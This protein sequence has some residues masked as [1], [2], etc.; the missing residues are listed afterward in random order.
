ME[1][2]I[3]EGNGGKRQ[4]QGSGYGSAA[5]DILGKRREAGGPRIRLGGNGDGII[6]IGAVENCAHWEKHAAHKCQCAL[7]KISLDEW[8]DRLSNSD[9][10][11]KSVRHIVELETEILMALEMNLNEATEALLDEYERKKHLKFDDISKGVQNHYD[12]VMNDIAK[13]LQLYYRGLVNSSRDDAYMDLGIVREARMKMLRKKAA[14]GNNDSVYEKAVDRAFTKVKTVSHDVIEDLKERWLAN[15]GPTDVVKNFLLDEEENLRGEALH[16]EDLR[17]RLKQ[18]WMKRRYIIQRIIRTETVNTHGTVQLN[19]WYEQGIREVERYEINDLKT[20]SLCRALALPGRNVYMIEDLLRQDYPV[21]YIS[22]PQCRGGY[23][24]RQNWSVFDDF[25]QKLNDFTNVQDIQGENGS[26]A[27]DVP[28]E[29]QTQVEKALNDFG[30]DYDIKFVPDI[31]DSKEWQTD[32]QKYWE[33]FY[34]AHDATVRVDLEKD[35]NRGKYIQ[36]ITDDGQVLV[37]G[38]AGDINRVVIPV[39]REKARQAYYG[40]EEADRQWVDE[41]YDRKKKEMGYT[42]EEEGVQI[43]GKVPFISPLAEHSAAD[44]FVESYTSYVADPTRLFYLDK[45]MYDFLRSK[46]MSTEYLVRGGIK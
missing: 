34:D 21:T 23:R 42:L 46:C 41:E 10:D 26:V 43:I 18:L 32:R 20:C 11:A 14:I 1:L 40:L 28:I 36:Y 39:L 12:L 25:E 37:S 9:M 13:P 5:R 24:P 38:D 8:R 29:Y 27:K 45:R 19:E 35:D 4:G 17:E 33:N 15:G 3:S 7:K 22:H 44:Y 31:V 16:R 2:T 6:R 30:P